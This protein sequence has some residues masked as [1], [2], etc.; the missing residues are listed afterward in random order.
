MLD[1]IILAGGLGTRSADP[2]VPKSLQTLVDRY[3]VLDSIADSVAG[4]PISRVIPVLG[5][6]AD[7][8]MEAFNAINWGA[9]LKVVMSDGYGTSRAV[10]MGSKEAVSE[11]ALIAMGD[12][13]LAIP[14]TEHYGEWVKLKSH[15]LGLCRFSDHPTDS[16]AVI[17][18][19]PGKIVGLNGPLDRG[20]GPAE[21]PIASLS[22]LVF[23]KT[24]LL[25]ELPPTGSFQKNLVDLANKRGYVIN[26]KIIRYFSRDTGTA[27][28]I[29]Q[30]RKAFISGSAARRAVLD[31]GAIFIDRDGTMIPNSG[32][33]RTH[34]SSTDFPE[35]VRQEWKKINELGIP[36]F[37]V[38]NQP[39]IAKGRIT[40]S[41]VLFTFLEI[42]R[43]LEETGAFFDDYRYCPHHPESGWADEI[44][45]LKIRCVCRKPG[46]GMLNDLAKAHRIDLTKSYVI[47]DSEADQKM[48]Y[49]VGAT[50]L[51][52]EAN[53]PDSVLDALCFAGK[54]L[55]DAS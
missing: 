49:S 44:E 16:D 1:L 6:Q 10:H 13:A 21:S 26:G 17:W 19:E 25:T 39:G 52:V 8:Q 54:G 23:S 12:S 3:T 42:Q 43:L 48:A 41:Q 24:N 50:F 7:S 29:D 15:A 27:S 51:Q 36:I 5:H 53:N 11:N 38:T 18:G 33:S 32:D 37:I 9:D 34:I 45:S 35:E 4:L 40:E 46:G 31:A 2:K 55:S 20:Q 22:G 14:L 30:V 47:G 28:R